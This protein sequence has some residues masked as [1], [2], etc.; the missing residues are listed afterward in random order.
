[1]PSETACIDRGTENGMY[2]ASPPQNV[3]G[4]TDERAHREK[5]GYP[6]ILFCTRAAPHLAAS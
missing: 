1:M 2:T 4:M 5:M 3:P 6:P